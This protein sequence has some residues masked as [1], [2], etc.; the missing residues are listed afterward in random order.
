MAQQVHAAVGE[1]DPDLHSVE[2]L[3]ILRRDEAE[4][5]NVF[6]VFELFSEQEEDQVGVKFVFVL[7][8]ATDG[9]DEAASLFVVRILPLGFDI[10]LEVLD[11]VDPT[12]LILD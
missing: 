9:E 1:V 12:P 2:G 11:G 4:T 8:V 5:T 6:A 10:L 3:G 7:L